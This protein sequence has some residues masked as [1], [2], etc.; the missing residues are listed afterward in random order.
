MFTETC[1]QGK[2][3]RWDAFLPRMP[4]HT[5]GRCQRPELRWRMRALKCAGDGA[6]PSVS[7]PCFLGT[8]PPVRFI[9]CRLRTPMRDRSLGPQ[10]A[11]LNDR[12]QGGRGRM[13]VG[14]LGSLVSGDRQGV[15]SVN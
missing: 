5:T 15:V 3:P 7:R 4:G 14:P 10:V 13:G 6:W 11:R 8:G 2:A 12:H 1:V 9:G